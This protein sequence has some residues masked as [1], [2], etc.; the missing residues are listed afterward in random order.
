MAV[1]VLVFHALGG[2]ISAYYVGP[3][4]VAAAAAS[5]V[6]LLLLPEARVWFR[7]AHKP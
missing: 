7:A 2:L 4:L 3:L 1:E 5:V 6:V